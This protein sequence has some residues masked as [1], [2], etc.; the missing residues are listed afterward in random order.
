MIESTNQHFKQIMQKNLSK[1]S[2]TKAVVGWFFEDVESVVTY[3]DFGLMNPEIM[4]FQIGSVTKLFTATLSSVFHYNGK[5]NLKGRVGDYLQLDADST[6]R[7]IKVED[8]LTHHGGVPSA[9]KELLGKYDKLNPYQ[10]IT[11][12]R[13][14]DYLNKYKKP[15]KS[16]RNFQY[17]NLGF[18]IMGQVLEEISGKTY[19]ELVKE[20]ICQPLEIDDIW[21]TPPEDDK[22]LAPGAMK[23]NKELSRWELNAIGAA[24]A[25][26]ANIKDMLKFAKGNL[27]GHPFYSRCEICHKANRTVSKDL[28]VGLG[29]M[30]TRHEGIG[31]LHSHN[32]STGGFNSFIGIHPE[33][34]FGVVVLTNCS[35]SILN[36]IGLSKDHAASIGFEGLKLIFGLFS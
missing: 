32:G 19:E 7:M 26:D 29:W 14:M 30:I 31:E 20:E 4:S 35:M 10:H 8:L 28:D 17:S 23:R 6:I 1:K 27:R 2:D 16:R 34:R 33:G 13:L 9:P 15:I 22:N 24:G 11:S 12:K 18:A 36:L 5:L 3:G 25:I 21:I